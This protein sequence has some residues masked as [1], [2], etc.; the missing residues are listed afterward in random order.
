MYLDFPNCF[1]FHNSGLT[2]MAENLLRFSWEM[3]NNFF[4]KIYIQIQTQTNI[5]WTLSVFI[6]FFL[7]LFFLL[8]FFWY[9]FFFIPYGHYNKRWTNKICLL[10]IAERKWELLTIAYKGDG[11]ILNSI[12]SCSCSPT[13][14]KCVANYHG[15]LNLG[16]YQLFTWILPI[17]K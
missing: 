13:I 15:I 5:T 6:W 16:V 17:F 7:T 4:P 3:R 8:L 2:N 1:T 12:E 14:V 11:R 9:W 10:Y